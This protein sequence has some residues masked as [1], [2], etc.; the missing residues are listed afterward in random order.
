LRSAPAGPPA[1]V[2]LAVIVGDAS[3]V[4]ARV[5]LVAAVTFTNV[6]GILSGLRYR[7]LSQTRCITS[8]WPTPVYGLLLGCSWA[9]LA[10]VGLPNAEHVDMRAIIA[11]FAAGTSATQ[12]V[13]AASH[14]LYFFATQIPLLG[15]LTAVYVSSDDHTTHLLGFAF[16][17]YLV[18]MIILHHDVNKVVVSEIELKHVNQDLISNLKTEQEQTESANAQL[19][20]ANHQLTE[21][22]MRDGLTGLANRHAFLDLLDRALSTVHRDNAVVGVLFFDVDRFKLVNDSLGHA[23]GDELLVAVAERVQ[24]ALRPIDTLGRLGGDEFVVLLPALGDSYEAVMIA[25]RIRSSLT[26]PINILGRR[27]RVTVSIGVATTL[28]ANDAAADLLRHADAA[29][30]NAKQNGR[31]RVEVFDIELRAR[32]QQIVDTEIELREALAANQIVPYFQPQV[33]V[34]TGAIVGAE[35]LARW[36]HPDRG[37]ITPDEFLPLAEA[38]GLMYQIDVVMMMQSVQARAALAELG[39]DPGFRIWS[40]VAPGVLARGNQTEQLAAY[41]RAAGCDPRGIGIE[42]TESGVLFDLDAARA[43]LRAARRLGL[44]VALDDFGT[45]YS[46]LSLLRD[47][48]IDEVKID[49]SFVRDLADDPV[50]AAIVAGVTEIARRIGL[51]VVAEGVETSAQDAEIRAL[52]CARAQGWRYGKPMPFDQLVERLGLAAAPPVP[53]AL[54]APVADHVPT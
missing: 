50:D 8:W 33:D 4:I 29:Q 34:M 7:K 40:N 18:V 12:I 19:V 26:E 54:P 10:V 38:T 39:V 36:L 1:A 51:D 5:A 47:L 42:I 20:T 24:R 53:S 28:H 43:E 46:S 30:Y 48:E 21:L 16:P 3:P 44:R 17:I 41:L 37:M 32:V 13:S 35:A 23:S 31:D 52:G 9:T 14:R 27:V 25:E 49:R 15:I 11:L 22:A 45:G 6:F 2:L